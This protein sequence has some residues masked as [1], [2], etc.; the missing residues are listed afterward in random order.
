MPDY[1][2]DSS[3]SKH[4]SQSDS[5]FGGKRSAGGALGIYANYPTPLG[6][7]IVDESTGECL[8]IDEHGSKISISERLNLRYKRQTQAR[9]ALYGFNETTVYNAKGFEQHHRT[10]YCNHVPYS[11]DVDLLKHPTTEKIHLSGLATCGS[12]STCPICESVISERRANELR[13][14]FT[15][16]KAMDLHIQLLTFTIPHTLGDDIEDLRPKISQAQQRFFAGKPWQKKREQYGIVA[17]ARSIEC[18]YGANGW[19]PHF[20]FIVFSERPLPKTHLND[21]SPN[22]KRWRKLDI[23]K[24]SPDW[25]WW[26]DRWANMCEKVGLDKPNEYGLDIRDGS[27]AYDYICKYGLDGERLTTQKGDKQLTW[28]MAD[29]ITKGNKKDGKK[30]FSPFQLLDVLGDS[31]TSTEDKQKARIQFIK[32]ARAMKGVPLMRWS[33]SAFDV[34]CF[35]DVSDSELLK[36]NNDECLL[37]AQFNVYQWK[38]ILKYSTRDLF[39]EVVNSGC[40]VDGIRSFVDSCVA[41]DTSVVVP[42]DTPV[43]EEKLITVDFTDSEQIEMFDNKLN[44]LSQFDDAAERDGQA[45]QETISNGDFLDEITRALVSRKANWDSETIKRGLK[46]QSKKDAIRNEKHRMY[47]RLFGGDNDFTAQPVSRRDITHY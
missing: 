47:V 2:H 42:I 21:L 29:E 11:K 3:K 6:L 28:D 4:P 22:S 16:A 30:S 41:Q 20:H 36:D 40:G 39:M 25:R 12:A 34:F 17:Y 19:H 9:K 13:S 24:Q 38:C 23:E 44:V 37:I 8:S 33:K 46:N 27:M 35:D 15:Q 43:E 32:Y 14:A 5:A 31:N 1:K 45:L 18:R 7:D 10:C 26:L